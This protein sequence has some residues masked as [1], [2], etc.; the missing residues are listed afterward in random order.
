MNNCS[1]D[2]GVLF[3]PASRVEFIFR[4]E[5][6]FGENKLAW[7]FCCELVRRNPAVDHQVPNVIRLAELIARLTTLGRLVPRLK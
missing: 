6:L 4:R 3:P 1:R 5:C 2:D 7:L